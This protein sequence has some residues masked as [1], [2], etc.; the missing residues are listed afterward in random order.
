VDSILDQNLETMREHLRLQRE[1]HRKRRYKASVKS[2]TNENIRQ[3]RNM[4]FDVSDNSITLV[5]M[6]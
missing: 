3:C 6:G 4:T 1:V 5:T 2:E